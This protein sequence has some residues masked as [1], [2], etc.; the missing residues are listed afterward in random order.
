MHNSGAKAE[1]IIVKITKAPKNRVYDGC[2]LY[3]FLLVVI[4][5]LFILPFG[6]KYMP[7]RLVLLRFFLNILK[8]SKTAE[9]LF[10]IV[11]I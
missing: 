9:Y 3:C 6:L 4:R 11:R 1:G 10:T 7:M 8:S 5:I 2:C